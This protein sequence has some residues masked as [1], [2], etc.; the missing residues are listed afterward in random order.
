MKLSNEVKVGMMVCAVVL[1]LMFLTVKAGN[2]HVGKKGYEIKVH[3]K[4][5]DGISL[6][7]PVM[8]NGFEV[9]LVK[10]INILDDAQATTIE[11]EVFVNSDVKLREGTQ[12]RVKNMGFMGEKYVSLSAGQS[13]NILPPASV[14]VGRDPTDLDEL[15][16]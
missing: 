3:F 10:K 11:L 6:N 4:R 5:I 14:I 12:A 2:F 9:G 15:L 1:C 8:L 16:E 7:A 13:G